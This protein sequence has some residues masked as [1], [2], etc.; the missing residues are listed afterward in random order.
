[1]RWRGSESSYPKQLDK[2]VSQTSSLNRLQFVRMP[3]H[4]LLLQRLGRFVRSEADAQRDQLRERWARPLSER[5]ARGFAIEGVQL[6]SL[7]PTDPSY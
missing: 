2:D 1:M 6:A 5:V 7:H 3:D 4:A